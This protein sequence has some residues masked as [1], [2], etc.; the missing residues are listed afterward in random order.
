MLCVN[1]DVE[2][3]IAAVEPVECDGHMRVAKE[4]TSHL[5]V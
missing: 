1:F 3:D 4:E 2:I 5:D